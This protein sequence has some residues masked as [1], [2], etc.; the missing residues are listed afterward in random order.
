[1]N[2]FVLDEDPLVAAFDHD[3][4][5]VVKMVLE[6]GQMLA[7]SLRAHG[8]TDEDMLAAGIVTKAGT[9]WRA[10]HK[11][12]PCTLWASETR[13]NFAWL[14]RHATAL[15]AAYTARF[16]RIHASTVAIYHMTQ[17]KHLIPDGPLTPFA[18]A[19]PDDFKSDDAVASYRAY[20]LSK[21]NVRWAH[22]PVPDWA[23]SVEG[24]A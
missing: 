5:R 14:S 4:V 22:V 20:Y 9:P 2:I 24:N 3:D 6:A 19:M 21:P 23:R 17:H 12:H 7:T 18:L 16:D 15:C 13:A 10:T 8:M 1:M 11:H